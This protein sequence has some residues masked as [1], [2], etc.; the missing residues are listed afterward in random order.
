VSTPADDPALQ[1]TLRSSTAVP[2][3]G[4]LFRIIP[5]S[6]IV[7]NIRF[8]HLWAGTAAGRCNPKGVARLYM[9]LE[10]ETAQA[11]FNYYQTLGGLDPVLSDWY[12]FAARVKFARVLDLRCAKTR[13]QVGLTLKEIGNEWDDDPL[14][15]RAVPARLQSIGYW[16]SKGYGDF[17]GI[18]YRSARRRAG[19]NIVIFAGRVTGTD[20]VVPISRAPT[21]GWP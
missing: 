12:S 21:K 3:E 2:F 14:H 13:K 4:H 11:E 16:I 1:A 19:H 8:E 18:V 10:R 5:G 17:S 9:S 15:P 6:S 20:F 7:R